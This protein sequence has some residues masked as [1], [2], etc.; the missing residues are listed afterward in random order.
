MKVINL[1]TGQIYGVY[2][3]V[4]LDV[5]TTITSTSCPLLISIDGILGLSD[6]RLICGLSFRRLQINSPSKETTIILS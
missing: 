3:L 6:D 2:S 5:I 4:I 1:I